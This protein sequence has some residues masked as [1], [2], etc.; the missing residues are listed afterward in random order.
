MIRSLVTSRILPSATREGLVLPWPIVALYPIYFVIIGVIL[1]TGMIHM[2][3]IAIPSDILVPTVLTIVLASLF[4]FI[5]FYLVSYQEMKAKVLELR[6][7]AM[8]AGQAVDDIAMA[9]IESFNN[10]YVCALL[11]GA[12]ITAGIA[13]LAMISIVPSNFTVV[14][15]IDYILG[16]IFSVIVAGVVL[17]KWFIHPIAD[18]SFKMKVIEP[19]ADSIID[20]FQTDGAET[21]TLTNEQVTALINALTGAVKKS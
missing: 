19:L 9:K 17:D 3:F 7:N 6:A 15:E 10:I 4:L 20:S 14:T 1:V 21:P 5:V 12:G 16:A 2:D 8:K 11:I 18:G 13:Y